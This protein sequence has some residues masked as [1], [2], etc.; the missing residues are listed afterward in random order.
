MGKPYRGRARAA[1]TSVDITPQ[2]APQHL[3]C[4]AGAV[5]F[6]LRRVIRY[7]VAVLEAWMQQRTATSTADE[8]ARGMA[9][10]DDWR[11]RARAAASAHRAVRR[12]WW[13]RRRGCAMR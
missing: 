6:A 7:K 1:R 13:T 4:D 8:P 2:S 9:W 10:P 3:A 5:E 12:A 11:S